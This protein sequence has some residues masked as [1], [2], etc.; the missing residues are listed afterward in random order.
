MAKY[1]KRKDGRY[2]TNITIGYTADGKR[3]QKKIYGKTIRELEDNVAEVRARLNKGI[4]IDDEGLTVR[5]WAE[6]W[7]RLY[8]PDVSYNTMQ[9]YRATINHI[10]K[11]LGDIRLST[12][13]TSHVQELINSLI[14]E[15]KP[16][17]AGKVK[18]A[19]GQLVKQAIANELI[20]K[21]IMLGV[22]LPSTPKTQKRALT[23]TEKLAVI[24]A[25]LDAKSRVYIDILLYTG[26][27]RGEALALT[28]DDIDLEQGQIQVNKTVIF[29]G[30][31][32]NIKNSPKTSAG[33]RV[34]PMPGVLVEELRRYI[35]T[36]GGAYVFPMST[37][38]PMSRASFVKFWRRI[39]K[40]ILANCNITPHMLRHTYATTLYYS[41][42]DIKTAQYL[43][44]HTNISVTMDIY[45]HLDGQQI[46]N[47]AEKLE[48]YYRKIN[49]E[50]QKGVNTADE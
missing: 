12:L 39:Q 17:V 29:A 45:T 46:Q 14:S 47:T 8:K 5:E 16:A 49:S 4:V 40:K 7:L 27:R 10:N 34:V 43:L 21:D 28:V 26:L 33:N 20:Y 50:G 30:N 31:K 37:G 6:K 2:A 15:G 23:D 18:L 38:D 3:K 9:S 44:G 41:G 36:L 19:C 35:G 11:A 13:K 24:N 32:S 1:K 48:N 42:V 22:V 25:D